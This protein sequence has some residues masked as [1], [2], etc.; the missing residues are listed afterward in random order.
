MMFS[1]DQLVFQ[2]YSK[3]E[4][5]KYWAKLLELSTNDGLVLKIQI[6]SGTR[7]TGTESFGKPVPIAL[8]LMEPYLDKGYHLFTSNWYDSS[9]SKRYTHITGT[10]R[11]D[12]KQ[13]L[14]QVIW[15]KLQNGEMV[16]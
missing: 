14:S 16:F 1:R 15:K 11:T 9:L 6:Y 7:F 2:P 4:M 13:N 10:L 12:L 5:H 8:H 3:N